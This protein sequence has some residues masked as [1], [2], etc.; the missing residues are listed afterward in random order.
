MLMMMEILMKMI[1]MMIMMEISIKIFNALIRT[2]SDVDKEEG[3]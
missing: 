2:Q 3:K 1:M